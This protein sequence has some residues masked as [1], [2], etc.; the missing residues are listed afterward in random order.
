MLS[1]TFPIEILNEI[2]AVFTHLGK[3]Y[4]SDDD[5]VKENN[6]T[7]AESHIKRAILDCY[8]YICMAYEDKYISFERMY[9]NT[10][11]SFIDNGDFLPNLLNTRKNAI[12]LML[13]ARKSDLKVKSEGEIVSDDTYQKYE[14]AFI[15]YSSVDDL[16]SN[17][18]L[19][20][21]NLRKKAVV[22]D[23]LL[24]SGWAFG[25]IALILAIIFKIF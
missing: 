16:I 7:K 24:I 14:K 21:E 6:V 22:K 11:L 5:L 15:A 4:L 9:K 13:D 12:D 25:L 20:L 17:S 23:F 2:R 18:F 3:Y 8:K 10:D 1:N 19:K